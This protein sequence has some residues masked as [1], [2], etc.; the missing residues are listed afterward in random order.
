ML[1]AVEAQRVAVSSQG[2]A[3]G[4]VYAEALATLRLGTSGEPHT[5]NGSSVRSRACALKRTAKMLTWMCRPTSVI[6]G[7]ADM[8]RTCQYVR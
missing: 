5:S 4:H 7:K 2:S 1:K 8:A 3:F 6:E